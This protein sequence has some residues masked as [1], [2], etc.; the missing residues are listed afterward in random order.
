[1]KT[2]SERYAEGLLKLQL[3]GSSIFLIDNAFG[4][5]LLGLMGGDEPILLK[6]YL[7]GIESFENIVKDSLTNPIYGGRMV[8]ENPAPQPSSKID[9]KVEENEKENKTE[10]P[11]D[12]NTKLESKEVLSDSG[13][14]NPKS[15]E[16][17]VD[18]N[19]IAHYLI[20]GVLTKRP[21]C[22]AAM[23]EGQL[24]TVDHRQN[25]RAIKNNSVANGGKIKG[26]AITI[27]SPGGDSNGVFDLASDISK[28]GE[29]IPTMTFAED[30]ALSAGYLLLAQGNQ[31]YAS[32]TARLGSVGV[33]TE[34]VSE[35]ELLKANKIDVRVIQAGEYKAIGH[36]AKPIDKTAI[37]ETQRRVDA[38][39]QEFISAIQTKKKYPKEKLKE[40]T[41]ARVFTPK[42][43]LN[44]GMITG[45]G[46]YEKA[47]ENFLSTNFSD[48]DSQKKKNSKAPVGV[49]KAK[50]KMD[51][52][53]ILDDDVELSQEPAPVVVHDSIKNAMSEY[54][55]KNK[56]TDVAGV[57]KLLANAAGFEKHRMSL[58]AGAEKMAAQLGHSETEYLKTLPVEALSTTIRGFREVLKLKEN[59][60]VV[61]NLKTEEKKNDVLPAG[62]EDEKFT[63]KDES[64]FVMG[65][66]EATK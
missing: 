49:K 20:S 11:D 22:M 23:M 19:G 55:I 31:Q 39:H 30:I 34:L 2:I 53:L 46:S 36:P 65:M 16:I 61:A 35:A 1:M 28:L 50:T 4:R 40:I 38:T 18:G 13:V 45:Y 7:T 12:S 25:I 44:L 63:I 26:A 5:S 14:D 17:L 32:R 59:P 48:D 51:D 15:G 8:V 10:N 42:E 21:N 29:I 24:G 57:E 60:A 56:I 62:N 27:E 66:M 47:Y 64:S 43:A 54:L 41:T 33:Y 58:V 52:E 9:V 3:F 6:N 37:D